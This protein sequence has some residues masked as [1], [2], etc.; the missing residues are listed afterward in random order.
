MVFHSFSLQTP[1]FIRENHAN[2]IWENLKFIIFERTLNIILN[3][4]N[5]Y[6]IYK[7]IILNKELVKYLNYFKENNEIFETKFFEESI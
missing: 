7:N 1:K 5:I 6:P 2:L 3:S 4:L